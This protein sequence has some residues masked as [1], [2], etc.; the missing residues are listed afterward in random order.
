MA[1]LDISTLRAAIKAA[2]AKWDAIE[3]PPGTQPHGLG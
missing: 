3:L 2:D 1:G